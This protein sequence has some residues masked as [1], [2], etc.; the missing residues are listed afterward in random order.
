LQADVSIKN[1]GDTKIAFPED[2]ISRIEVMPI[3]ATDGKGRA[4]WQDCPV[5][6]SEDF[7]AHNNVKDKDGG[8]LEPNEEIVRSVAFTMPDEWDCCKIRVTLESDKM[9]RSGDPMK[10]RAERVILRNSITR[11]PGSVNT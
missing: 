9:D 7:L 6:L 11:T 1:P 5:D 4:S 3:D 2:G 8:N 10:W